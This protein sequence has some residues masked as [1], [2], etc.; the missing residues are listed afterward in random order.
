M[1]LS[2]RVTEDG[3]RLIQWSSPYPGP[4]RHNLT[5]QLSYRMEDQD[6]WN[7]GIAPL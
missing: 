5:Y 7:V 1:D 6:T 2:V 4:S 3:D